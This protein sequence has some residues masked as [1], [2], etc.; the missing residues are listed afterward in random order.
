VTTPTRSPL[1]ALIERFLPRLRYP[2][3]VLALGGLLLVDL[4]VPD[5]LPLVDELAL[6]LLTLI[7]ASLRTGR[8]DRP[9]PRDITPPD[10]T[11]DGP[12][13]PS[14]RLP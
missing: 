8:A 7:A 3:L 1:A 6:A 9:P 11:A 5:P 13:P 12:Q 14:A 2:W 4:V 10:E